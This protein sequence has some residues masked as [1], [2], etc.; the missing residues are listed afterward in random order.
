MKESRL[1]WKCLQQGHRAADCRI[2][3]RCGVNGCER[4][5]H[6]SLHS[7]EIS[8]VTFNTEGRTE[9]SLSEIQRD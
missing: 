7:A 8:G 9:S 1:C 5:H 3:D 6:A 4:G 2:K